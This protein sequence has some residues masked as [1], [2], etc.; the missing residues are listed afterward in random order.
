MSRNLPVNSDKI[1]KVEEKINMNGNRKKKYFYC[2]EET[3]CQINQVAFQNFQILNDKDNQS[4]LL[5]FNF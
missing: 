4:N 1:L 3:N 5:N 2:T